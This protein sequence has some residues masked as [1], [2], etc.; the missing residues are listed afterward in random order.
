[1]KT[2]ID[3]KSQSLEE[4]LGI[5]FSSVPDHAVRVIDKMEVGDV[6]HQGDVYLH[7]VPSDHPRGA[8]LGTR[9]LAI[10]QGEGSNHFANGDDVCVYAGVKLP[11]W[12]VDDAQLLGPLVEV[13]KTW[14]N[15]HTTHAHN[16]LPAGTIQVTYQL[17]FVT[18]QR[19]AD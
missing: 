4:A 16:V 8:L 17:D 14:R 11:D 1:M 12:V 10:G 3:M 15:T 7:R 5:I 19:V 2:T 6:V 18:R 9:K 13:P